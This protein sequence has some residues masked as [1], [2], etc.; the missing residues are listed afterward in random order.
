MSLHRVRVFLGV[1]IS[2]VMVAALLAVTLIAGAGDAFAQERERAR[3]ARHPIASEDYYRGIFLAQGPV[4]SLIPEI[5]DNLQLDRAK[6]DPLVVRALDEFHARLTDRIRATDPTFMDRF[7]AAMKSHDHY[8]I[9][10]AIGEGARV[11]LAAVQSMPEIVELRQRL[12]NDPQYANQLVAEMRTATNNKYDEGTLRQAINLFASN[13]TS[14]SIETNTTVVIAV[15]AVAALTIATVFAIANAVAIAVHVT[16]AFN[17][18][19]QTA[20][21]KLFREQLVNS[22]ARMP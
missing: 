14:D 3:V 20:P 15:V 19:S 7:A 8:T 18:D 9:D 16:F 6:N 1:P 10:A 21:V 5:R 4:A 17:N 12:E 13:A 22:I 2:T 11:M